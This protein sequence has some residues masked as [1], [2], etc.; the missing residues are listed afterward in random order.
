MIHFFLMVN[1]H[2]QTRLADYFTKCGTPLRCSSLPAGSRAP[3]PPR[4][5]LCRTAG[6][7]DRPSSPG[8]LRRPRSYGSA[9]RG[10]ITRWGLLPRLLGLCDYAQRMRAGVA[11]FLLH[12]QGER[13]RAKEG[14]VPAVC[15]AFLHRGDVQRGGARPRIPWWLAPCS[16]Q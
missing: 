13:R 14:D 11:V 10:R 12:A 1:K 15:L 9:S 4:A 5:A 8:R 3:H 16:T 7:R 2:G 6:R